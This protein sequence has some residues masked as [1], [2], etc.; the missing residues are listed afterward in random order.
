M[1]LTYL[2]ELILSYD[3][4]HLGLPFLLN[5]LFYH[6]YINKIFQTQPQTS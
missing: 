3:K 5:F 2:T 6:N 1:S 4:S